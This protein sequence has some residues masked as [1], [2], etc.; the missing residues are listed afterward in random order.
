M[1][2]RRESAIAMLEFVFEHGLY[3]KH[4]AGYSLIVTYWDSGRYEEA[5]EVVERILKEK[6]SPSVTDLYYKGRILASFKRWPE[7][8]SIFRQVLE[9]LSRSG[10][11]G[12]G[13]QVEC[14]YWIARALF[15]QGQIGAAMP[16]LACALEQ[17]KKRNARDEPEGYF[18][19]HAEI[20]DL[21]LDLNEAVMQAKPTHPASSNRI[22]YRSGRQNHGSLAA[23]DQIC[24]SRFHGTRER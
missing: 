2:D 4:E 8:E 19:S 22:S 9:R 5:L 21:I 14:K 17:N 11:A 20:Q 15:E 10:V 6:E 3:A 16:F 7:L 1:E 12:D 13:Y 23:R 24:A 18:E